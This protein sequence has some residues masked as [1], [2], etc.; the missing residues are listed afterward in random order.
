[1]ASD[2]DLHGLPS[3]QQCLDTSAVE[4]KNFNF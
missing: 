2:Q 4:E 1:M 3:I